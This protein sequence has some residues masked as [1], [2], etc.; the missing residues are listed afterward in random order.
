ML[1]KALLLLV[2]SSLL[3]APAA[4]QDN[5]NPIIAFL[6]FGLTPT[7]S[8]VRQGV[9]DMLQS[10]GFIN[11]EEKLTTLGPRDLPEDLP[12]DLEGEHINIIWGNA[13]FDLSTMNLLVDRMLDQDVDVFVTISSPAAQSAVNATIDM[14]EPPPVFFTAVYN[15]YQVGI[16]ESPCIKPAHVTGSLAEIA[17]EDIM[18]LL[19]LQDPNIK[20]IG[21]IYNSTESS[22]RYDAERIVEEGQALGLNVEVTAVSSL[23]DLSPAAEG[24][25][26]KGIEVFLL[27]LDMMTW[28]GIPIISQIAAENSVPIFHTGIDSIYDTGAAVSTGYFLYFDQG[29]NVGRMLAAYLKGELDVATTGISIQTSDIRVAMNVN[30]AAAQGFEISD[31]LAQKGDMLVDENQAVRLRP[32]SPLRNEYERL[33]TEPELGTEE[34]LAADRAFLE[35]LACTPEQIAAEQ[36]ELDAQSE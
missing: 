18:P 1:K 13:N 29:I 3:L 12:A 6:E 34:Q 36:A 14:D 21:T 2:L 31:A 27:P 30:A 7:T 8:V 33:I 26:N 24:L 11:A 19:L 25:V 32:N 10:H 16:A 17:Y 23:A 9:L 35:S 5:D 28:T 20:T 4:A 22:A 15:P